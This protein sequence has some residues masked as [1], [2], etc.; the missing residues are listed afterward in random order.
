M[1][2]VFQVLR[3]MKTLL[4]LLLFQVQSLSPKKLSSPVRDMRSVIRMIDGN[5]GLAPGNDSR[6]ATGDLTAI[7]LNVMPSAGSMND[8]SQQ[9]YELKISGLESTATSNLKRQKVE[10]WYYRIHFLV[11]AH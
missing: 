8:S 2:Y 11:W 4:L 1:Q 5:G 10:V 3:S 6:V 9:S 7:T